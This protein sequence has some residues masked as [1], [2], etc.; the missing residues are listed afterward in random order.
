MDARDDTVELGLRA[1]CVDLLAIVEIARKPADAQ[2]A[3]PTPTPPR[4]P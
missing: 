1:Q 3:L 4:K 2:R